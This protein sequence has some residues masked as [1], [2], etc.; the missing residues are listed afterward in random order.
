MV[1]NGEEKFREHY[2]VNEEWTKTVPLAEKTS[3]WPEWPVELSRLEGA[4]AFVEKEENEAFT[5]PGDP[6]ERHRVER[7]RLL[8]QRVAE[9]LALKPSKPCP[10]LK[11][12]EHGTYKLSPDE[13]EREIRDYLRRSRQVRIMQVR[14]QEM[15][16]AA[17]RVGEF[18]QRKKNE[19]QKLLQ[20]LK[21]AWQEEHNRRIADVEEVLATSCKGIGQ[22]HIA[23]QEVTKTMA[24]MAEEKVKQAE[25][26][27]LWETLRY[28]KAKQEECARKSETAEVDKAAAKDRRRVV[29]CAAEIER[30]RARCHASRVKSKSMEAKRNPSEEDPQKY[31]HP[32][33]NSNDIKRNFVQS[34]LAGTPNDYKDTYFHSRFCVLKDKT[35]LN[36]NEGAQE[37]QEDDERDAW[38]AAEAHLKSVELEQQQRAEAEELWNKRKLERGQLAVAHLQKIASLEEELALEIVQ[39]QERKRQLQ[40]IEELSKA[41]HFSAYKSDQKRQFNSKPAVNKVLEEQRTPT[42]EE[43]IDCNP[44]DCSGT[45]NADAVQP[46]TS[47]SLKPAEQIEKGTEPLDDSIDHKSMPTQDVEI[48]SRQST[49]DTKRKIGNIHGKDDE[50]VDDKDTEIIDVR[51]PVP[52]PSGKP[53]TPQKILEIGSETKIDPPP[54]MNK[55]CAQL[56]GKVS[57][58]EGRTVASQDATEGSMSLDPNLPGRPRKMQ[59]ARVPTKGQK[60]VAST[61][62]VSSLSNVHASNNIRKGNKSPQRIN[63]PGRV[64]SKGVENQGSVDQVKEVGSRPR[65]REAVPPEKKSAL[66]AM[67]QK[68]EVCQT[69]SRKMTPRRHSGTWLTNVL[70]KLTWWKSHKGK[71]ISGVSAAQDTAASESPTI[72]GPAKPFNRG[73]RKECTP[74]FPVKP[75]D[76]PVKSRPPWNRNSLP[77]RSK[78]MENTIVAVPT[79]L[80][81]DNDPGWYEA[82]T[83]DVFSAEEL[84]ELQLELYGTWTDPIQNKA[85]PKR[86]KVKV[87]QQDKDSATQLDGGKVDIE[88]VTAAKTPRD[89]L[90]KADVSL[91]NALYSLSCEPQSAGAECQLTPSLALPDGSKVPGFQSKVE[92]GLL[93]PDRFTKKSEFDESGEPISARDVAEKLI[94]AWQTGHRGGGV[95]SPMSGPTKQGTFQRSRKRRAQADESHTDHNVPAIGGKLDRRKNI[96]RAKQNSATN[97][98]QW[99]VPVVWS[100]KFEPPEKKVDNRNN[101]SQGKEKIRN[102]RPTPNGPSNFRVN[103]CPSECKTEALQ[104]KGVE[105][106]GPRSL[107]FILGSLSAQ[108]K[109][110]DERLR[111]VTSCALPSSFPEECCL[112]GD[113]ERADEVM[114]AGKT[115]QV[116]DHV[117]LGVRSSGCVG[118]NQDCKTTSCGVLELEQLS[119]RATSMKSP[120]IG[121][122]MVFKGDGTNALSKEKDDSPRK[123]RPPPASPCLSGFRKQSIQEAQSP[124]PSM[125]SCL[126]NISDLMK[127][128]SRSP[129][130]DK[131]AAPQL[132]QRSSLESIPRH[133]EFSPKNGRSEFQLFD[134]N[135]SVRAK[136]LEHGTAK[137][138]NEKFDVQ[139]RLSLKSSA[140]LCSGIVQTQ[141]DRNPRCPLPFERGSL[142]SINLEAAMSLDEIEEQLLLS[143][144]VDFSPWNTEKLP[145]VFSSLTNAAR[146]INYSEEHGNSPWDGASVDCEGTLKPVY[147][148]VKKESE[149][150]LRGNKLK[151]KS[152]AYEK[153]RAGKARGKQKKSPKRSFHPV[154]LPPKHSSTP[155]K[156]SS[157]KRP[158]TVGVLPKVSTTRVQP[159][160]PFPG[161]LKFQKKDLKLSNDGSSS[162]MNLTTRSLPTQFP[163]SVTA[164]EVQKWLSRDVAACVAAPSPIGTP[165]SGRQHQFA[166][167]SKRP[168][169]SESVADKQ[170]KLLAQSPVRIPEWRSKDLA[171]N[172]KKPAQPVLV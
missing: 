135:Y 108:V 48:S 114:P 45:L 130:C 77:V 9:T 84:E 151:A 107:D 33:F 29:E 78:N 25:E 13:E 73:V 110:L 102:T 129:G 79:E 95:S 41:A 170:A 86:D 80:H 57:V 15:L 155:R 121:G 6:H 139:S 161:A 28:Q 167:C 64:A 164:E 160:V 145:D 31:L 58:S 3:H 71:M 83:K 157:P 68:A 65:C 37:E 39:E 60:S 62:K 74:K 76:S 100:Q 156:N 66:P 32:N 117:S 8:E 132:F 127:E 162:K 34:R 82:Y 59:T 88:H 30:T 136:G 35:N 55:N 119:P 137:N 89:I 115:S 70:E 67:P 19:K 27:R 18:R 131:I 101:V 85:K 158:S 138:C 61:P 168:E 171:S 12:S 50:V 10:L 5:D 91:S 152:K 56:S 143:G 146:S 141:G 105:D 22:S 118:E 2:L 49:P 165:P 172:K 106:I 140:E 4:V 44:G 75:V 169:I 7:R 109:E 90:E 103:H 16:L 163:G 113:E 63:S 20:V 21:E 17:R 23:A 54:I 150:L 72:S 124:L 122:K 51:I 112:D 96:T 94:Q 43:P 46:A 38:E 147:C 81:T 92:I 154:A 148:H 42:T 166:G 52:E 14:A 125:A 93:S 159:S 104:N 11:G 47:E 153:R 26:S 123:L 111:H 149:W 126:E 116:M 98:G 120:S 142:S 69:E 144:S 53:S 1:I 87:G 97:D 128:M 36:T 134:N 133:P 99:D 40:I 24:A